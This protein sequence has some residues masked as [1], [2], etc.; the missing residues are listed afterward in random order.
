MQNGKSNDSQNIKDTIIKQ[1]KILEKKEEQFL[2]SVENPIMKNTITPFVENIEDLIPLKIEKALNIAFYKGFQL[3]FEKGNA[4]IEKTYDKDKIKLEHECYD[5]AAGK[6]SHIRYLKKMDKQSKY[7]KTLNS[8]IATIEGSVLG[9]LGVG[10][11][12]IPL[13]LALII[14][15]LNEIAL[16]YGMDYDSEEEK[17][18]MLALISCALSS[19]QKKTERNSYVDYLSEQIS[20]NIEANINLENQIKES[21]NVLSQALLTAKFIQGIPLV[22][23]VGGAVNHVIIKKIGKYATIKY[24]KRYLLRKLKEEGQNGQ[25]EKRGFNSI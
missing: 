24:K 16:S 9:L 3:V 12:D 22:G 14:K 4:I 10:L 23:I 8:S 2:N 15:N 25:K 21:S 19:P 1:L 17:C 20:N 11:P 5:Y 18:Y 13:F 6:T 7:S